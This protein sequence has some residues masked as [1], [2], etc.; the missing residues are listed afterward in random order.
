MTATLP[1]VAAKKKE[2]VEQTAEQQAA[3][4][5]VR[6]AMEQGLSLTGP[7]GLLRAAHE[8]GHRGCVAG[9]DDRAPGVVRHE[10]LIDHVGVRDHHRRLVV[11]GR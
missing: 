11:A 7:D 8:D 9:G 2:Q 6:L 10:A 1:D 4:E 3:A 5:L